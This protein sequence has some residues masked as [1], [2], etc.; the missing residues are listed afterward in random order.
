MKYPT[1]ISIFKIQDIMTTE[2]FYF[3]DKTV[4]LCF[5]ENETQQTKY[6]S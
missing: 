4:K 6:L 2:L 1:S 3:K 5:N